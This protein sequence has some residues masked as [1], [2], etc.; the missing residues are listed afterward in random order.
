MLVG[1][2]LRRITAT[3]L[4]WNRLSLPFVPRYWN[5][6]RACFG[7]NKD[8]LYQWTEE[9]RKE[10]DDGRPEE[11]MDAINRCSSLPGYDKVICEREIGYFEKNKERMRY[12]DFRK[13]GLFVGS[14]VLEAGCRTVVGKIFGS[15][16]R[17]RKNRPH[18]F[19]AHPPL[20]F[21]LTNRTIVL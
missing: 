3:V 7:Q 9:R 1:I 16:V 10:L 12:A 5:V 15:I 13:R 8:K 20:R 2:I 14:G 11:V 21:S 18:K 4:T 19:V 17:R 6:A